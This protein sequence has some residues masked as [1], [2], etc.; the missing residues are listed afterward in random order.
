[1]AV[2]SEVGLTE[3]QI[4]TQRKTNFKNKK[5]T[6]L[7]MVMFY[8]SHV[9]T[10]HFVAQC[11]SFMKPKL[12]YFYEYN[13]L[14]EKPTLRRLF[15]RQKWT[16]YKQV[17]YHSDAL[18]L[19]FQ[20]LLSLCAKFV[21]NPQHRHFPSHQTYAQQWGILR[22]FW[23]HFDGGIYDFADPACVIFSSK[24]SQIWKLRTIRFLAIKLYNVTNYH[25][26][27][28]LLNLKSYRMW[29]LSRL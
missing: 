20:I 17:L 21:L 8:P 15:F 11:K 18:S 27:Q 19:D 23:L 3:S 29:A 26:I 7:T 4:F 14:Y 5:H 22:N 2:S 12:G 28:L 13:K 1:M 25:F 10:S 24:N 6:I 9:F 16:K